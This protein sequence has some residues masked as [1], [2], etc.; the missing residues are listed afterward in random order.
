MKNKLSNF[1]IN[2]TNSDIAAYLAAVRT[3][4][5]VVESMRH[6]I[7]GFKGQ[8]AKPIASKLTGM[9]SDIGENY[10]KAINPK[11]SGLVRGVITINTDGNGLPEF[12]ISERSKLML[13]RSEIEACSKNPD[14]FAE[15]VNKGWIDE[16]TGEPLAWIKVVSKNK[17]GW[18]SYNKIIFEFHL[19]RAKK[20]ELV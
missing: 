19:C 13:E 14:T 4:D 5:S 15:E 9:M 6:L 7:K 18:A 8:I 17:D 2:S 16:S 3:Q 12:W 10:W 11:I 1:G 20:E